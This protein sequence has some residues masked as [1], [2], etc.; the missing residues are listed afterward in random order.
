[1]EAQKSLSEDWLLWLL[2]GG[3]LVLVIGYYFLG[4]PVQ[5]KQSEPTWLFAGVDK[6]SI[7]TIRSFQGN[8]LSFE[9]RAQRKSDGS[10]SYKLAGNSTV[11]ISQ[12]KINEWI[13]TVLNP[14]IDA[15]FKAKPNANY[16]F[17]S[18]VKKI[19][20]TQGGSLHTL[21]VGG[22]RYGGAG[23]YLRYGSSENAPI[24]V[25][26]NSHK[27]NIHKTLNDI[28][29]QELF[30]KS[31]NDIKS[32]TLSQKKSQIT[33]TIKKSDWEITEPGTRVLNDTE[34]RDLEDSIRQLLHMDAENFYDT[35]PSEMTPLSASI[36]VKYKN[37][38][39]D[40]VRI[41][42]EKNQSR[43]VQKTNWPV[44]EGSHD[45]IKLFEQIP[46]LPD[47]WPE[48]ISSQPQRSRQKQMPK[49]PKGGLKKKLQMQKQKRNF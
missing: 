25:I 18:P 44:I 30:T 17:D 32:I 47:N 15:Q 38:K 9:L 27:G 37:G 22:D 13:D 46:V 35:S 41:G 26:S 4:M 45:P 3:A 29:R 14:T 48:G 36:T 8:E 12:D 19:E 10:I 11:K 40:T 28:R 2:L 31:V 5:N 1:M 33:Y 24:Y 43:L 49:M 34:T 6:S 42:G 21:F 23:F 20:I 39:S 16:G 7:K